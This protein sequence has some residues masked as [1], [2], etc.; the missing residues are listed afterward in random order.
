MIFYLD[1]KLSFL[2]KIDLQHI[3]FQY[4]KITIVM[5][6]YIFSVTH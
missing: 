2:L 1:L 3:F 6:G 4:K 5:I